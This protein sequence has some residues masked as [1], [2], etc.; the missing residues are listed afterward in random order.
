MDKW[1]VIILILYF[2][3]CLEFFIIKRGERENEKERLD[4]DIYRGVG[5]KEERSLFWIGI[6]HAEN[7][8]RK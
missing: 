8:P 2:C 4:L 6:W 7:W 5:D 1:E 3:I